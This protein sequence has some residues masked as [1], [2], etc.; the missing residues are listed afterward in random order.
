MSYRGWCQVA[1]E[2]ELS[3]ALTPAAVGAT[4]LVLARTPSGV[5]VFDAT[6]PHRGADLGYGGRLEGAAIVCPFHGHRVGLGERSDDGFCAREH[7]VLAVSGLVFVLLDEAPEHGLP[8]HLRDLDRDHYFVPGF[9]LPVQAPAD[10]VIENGFD[11]AHFAAVH[12]IGTRPDMVVRAGM[13]GELVA[14]GLF[15]LPRGVGEA[16]D[17]PVFAPYVA[18]AFS[19]WVIV[20][21]LRGDRPY[22]VITAAT[23]T[24]DGGCTIR[25]TLLVPAA[26]GP[27]SSAWCESMLRHSREGL[28]RDRLIWEHLA[29]AVNPRLTPGDAPVVAFREFCR[30]FVEAPA[31][32]ARAVG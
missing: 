4:R 30:R 22:R 10:L 8:A 6:C 29:P 13:H 19:P 28:E 14:E 20:S 7:R 31:A 2:R 9:T 23:P 32:T 21:E 5:R 26:D 15:A 18:R 11:N 25:L 16:S 24:A 1:F 12:G 17:G 27:P 3:P